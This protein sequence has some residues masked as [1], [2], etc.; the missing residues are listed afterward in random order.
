[1][2]I[3]SDNPE[4]FDSWIEQQALNGRFGSE[5]QA[6]VNEGALCGWELWATPGI[7]LDGK[8]GS[9]ACQAYVERLIP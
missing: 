1:M 9:E 2:S 7:D 5:V 8:L 3:W 6:K 4:W